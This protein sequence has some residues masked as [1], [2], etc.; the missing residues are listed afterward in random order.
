MA[1]ENVGDKKVIRGKRSPNYP[2]L[3]LE[4]SLEMVRKLYDAYQQKAVPAPL[5][6][7]AMGYSIKSGR[8]IQMMA[9]LSYYQLIDAERGQIENR[10]VNVTNLAVTIIKHPDPKEREKA[11]KEAALNPSIFNKIIEKYPGQLPQERLLEWNLESEY[12]FNPKSIKDFIA[13]FRQTMDFAKIYEK[14]IIKEESDETKE[15]HLDEEED[16]KMGEIQGATLKLKP[17]AEYSHTPPL[18]AKSERQVAMYPV[19][20]DVSV[21]LIA[22]G[23]ITMKSIEKL[24]QMLKINK[25]DFATDEE[26]AIIQG[27]KETQKK[28]E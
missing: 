24:I 20:R 8:S 28:P 2:I 27:E 11:I 26:L 7:E 19:G 5:A 17:C 12:E 10:K 21:R 14:G 18:D 1:E 3:T 6:M 4:K 22:S 16:K 15:Y 13:V 9:S 25:E 23:P